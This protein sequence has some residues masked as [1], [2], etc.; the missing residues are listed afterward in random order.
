MLFIY[1]RPDP[2]ELVRLRTIKNGYFGRI[3]IFSG[4]AAVKPLNRQPQISMPKS[5][6]FLMTCLLIKYVHFYYRNC[7]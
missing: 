3:I 6:I 2:Y 5:N 1:N 4:G 7:I